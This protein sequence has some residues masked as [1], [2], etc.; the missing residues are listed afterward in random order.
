[1][2]LKIQLLHV[3]DRSGVSRK[4]GQPYRICEAQ[5]VVYAPHPESGEVT[6]MVGRFMIPRGQEDEIVR[7]GP[8][9]YLAEFTLRSDMQGRIEARVA[10]LVRMQVEARPASKAA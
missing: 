10:K 5:A 2:R 9:D 4:T 8:G 7:A 6:P 3:E 1:M